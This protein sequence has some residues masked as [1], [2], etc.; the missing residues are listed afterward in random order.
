MTA[1]RMMGLRLPAEL[2][3]QV[4]QAAGAG[5]ASAWIRDAIR[6]R[7]ERELAERIGDQS[8]DAAP[9]A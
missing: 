8:H 4:K 9:P 1:M 6:L 3:D 2:L 5:D 7:L